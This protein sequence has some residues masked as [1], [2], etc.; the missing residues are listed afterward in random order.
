[1]PTTKHLKSVR[2]QC[3]QQPLRVLPLKLLLHICLFPGLSSPQPFTDPLCLVLP[4]RRPTSLGGCVRRL[5]ARADLARL[6]SKSWWL[7]GC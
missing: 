5:E 2:R 4:Q 6:C 3:P 7:T 1:M